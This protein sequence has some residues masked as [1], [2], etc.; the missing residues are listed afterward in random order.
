MN[1]LSADSA[2]GPV[3]VLRRF[4]V[5]SLPRPAPADEHRPARLGIV[6]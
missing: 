3:F 2:G 5:A 1:N 4:L 6:A